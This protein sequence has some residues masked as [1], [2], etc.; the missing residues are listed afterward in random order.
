MHN[1]FNP[2]AG[3]A[4]SDAI[5]ASA[6]ARSVPVVSSKQMLTW[7]DGR[8]GSSFQSMAWNGTMLSFTVAVGTGATGLQAMLPTTVT[9]GTLSTLTLN[10]S[11]VSFTV[12]TIKGVQYAT[13]QVGAGTYQATYTP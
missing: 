6:L 13:F 3:Q 1:D 7:L 8:N 4:G 12:Q 2:S 11:P 9:A 10:G 5:V